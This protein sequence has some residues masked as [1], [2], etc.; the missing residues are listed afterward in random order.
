MS[1][2]GGTEKKRK[3]VT[4]PGPLSYQ[5]YALMLGLFVCCFQGNV[6]QVSSIPMP[7]MLSRGRMTAV[8]SLT[9]KV[10]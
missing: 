5:F 10:I 1:Q 4:G 7:S 3:D 6:V 8:R 9:L 2:K